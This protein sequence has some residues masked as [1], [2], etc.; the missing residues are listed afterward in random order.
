[1]AAPPTR[2]TADAAKIWKSDEVVKFME[3]VQDA[4]QLYSIG[5]AG[6]ILDRVGAE[7]VASWPN[8]SQ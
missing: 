7:T 4:T 5:A 1:M 8:P 3:T 2:H 6:G